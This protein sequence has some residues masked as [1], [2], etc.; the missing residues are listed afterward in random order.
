[1]IKN[2]VSNPIFR[3]LIV[4]CYDIAASLA[5]IIAALMLRLDE[6]SLFGFYVI[7]NDFSTLLAVS[8][9]VKMGCF[10]LFNVSKGM[11][12]FT[13]APDLKEILKASFLAE[14]IIVTLMFLIER[15]GYI[16][17]TAFLMD[18]MLTVYF[19]AGGRILYRFLREK[20]G[21]T[22]KLGFRSF[23]SS[24]NDKLKKAIIIGAGNVAERLLR[25]LGRNQYDFQVVGLLDDEANKQGRMILGYK[26]LGKLHTIGDWTKKFGAEKVIIAISSLSSAEVRNI[27]TAINDPAVEIVTLPSLKDI[28]EG[29]ISVSEMR[30]IDVNDL[31]GRDPVQLEVN[32]LAPIIQG[33]VVMVTGAGGSIGSELVRQLAKLGPSQLVLFDN[34]E[35]FLY[36]LEQELKEKFSHLK[37][38]LRVGDVR[39]INRLN[40]VLKEFQPEACYH[41]AAYKHVP[42]MEANPH[43]AIKVNVFGTR[44][45]LEACKNH[46]VKKFVL[47]STDKA[48]RPT[49]VMGATKKVAEMICQAYAK[50]NPDFKVV[51]VRF[52]NVLASHGS[53]VPLFM[54]QIKRGGPVTVTHKDMT[55]Y[56][57]SIPEAAQLVLNAGAIGESGSIMILEMGEPVKIM[58][59]ARQLIQLSGL[60]PD[61]DIEI[62]E[63]GLR[64]GEKLFEELFYDSEKMHDTKFS[65]IKVSHY[66]EIGNNYL[67]E[68]SAFEQ[69]FTS[70]PASEIR[71]AL[72]L[73]ISSEVEDK[74][75]HKYLQ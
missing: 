46:G 1:M 70:I 73:I 33:K 72:A 71:K 37:F 53:V 62:K 57:M 11:W 54:D 56:F 67:N 14:V 52:G 69:K 27:V 22:G 58:D 45:V 24:Q 74:E 23:Y 47:V 35:F 18:A 64:P 17:R 43:E 19:V 51:V 55:R 31:L 2:V 75:I 28:V 9:A 63:I 20:T 4:Y 15:G 6:F 26:I 66:H 61:V 29:K 42:M 49:S 36:E 65:K 60:K 16:P 13:S 21:P 38:H 68:L 39:D 41:A 32:V 34:N 50:M 44:N 59:L 10:Y 40:L 48:V 12:R 5:A 3:K 30:K 25:D 8:V 7:Y